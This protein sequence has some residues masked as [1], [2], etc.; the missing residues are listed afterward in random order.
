[1]AVDPADSDPAFVGAHW[2]DGG[3]L[4]V[5]FG[6]RGHDATRVF[7]EVGAL[8]GH[9]E[10]RARRILVSVPIGLPENEDGRRPDA[11]ARELLGPQASTVPPVP[12]REATR[13]R[14]HRTADRVHRRRAGTELPEAAFR[15]APPIAALDEL[16]S[17]IPEAR[18]AFAESHPELCF[19]AFAGEPIE[20][21]PGVAAGYA[22]RMRALVAHDRDAPPTVQAVAEGTA[23]HAVSVRSVL[24]ATALAYT[25]RPGDGELRSLPADPEHDSRGL[26]MR[27]RY[28]AERPLAVE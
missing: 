13:K 15:R 18:E 21:P 9:Y 14:T 20:E 7:E 25:A 22:E 3:W 19:R 5:A 8:W 28:R 10:E 6:P 24:A 23:G 12:V 1:M 2:A 17:E 11:L 4:A 26:P 16:L 27:L